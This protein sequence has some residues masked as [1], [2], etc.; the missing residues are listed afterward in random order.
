[1]KNLLVIALALTS[2]NIDLHW[3]TNFEEAKIKASNED[4]KVLIVFSGSDWCKPCIQLHKTLFETEDF[5]K[6][7]KDRL[8]LVKADFPSR[9]KNQLSREQT[10]RN[11]ALASKY[12]AEGVFPLAVFVDEN[13]KPLGS[14]GFD[15]SKAPQDYITQFNKYL[16]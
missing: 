6:F 7:A 2:L 1:M 5:Q 12:N 13:G 10:E 15:K 14:F 4:K 9:K 11:E 8:I 16:K 3:E